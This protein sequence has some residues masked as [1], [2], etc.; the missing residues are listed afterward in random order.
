[1]YSSTFY[2]HVTNAILD[3][4]TVPAEGVDDYKAEL[5][6]CREALVELI[7]TT[8]CAPILVR[9]AWHDSG[10]YNKVS[11]SAR[12]FSLF[13]FLAESVPSESH[14]GRTSRSGQPAAVLTD[15]SVSSQKSTTVLMRALL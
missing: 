4:E 12:L 3:I 14:F 15:P 11:C 2:R 1:M 13:S 9:L 10:T 6:K 8:S 7:Q 5:A